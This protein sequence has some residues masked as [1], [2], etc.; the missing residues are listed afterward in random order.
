MIHT[1]FIQDEQHGRKMFKGDDIAI[2]E[3]VELWEF[4]DNALEELKVAFFRDTLPVVS[5]RVEQQSHDLLVG[6]IVL[7]GEE[8]FCEFV[9]FADGF[10]VGKVGVLLG[11]VGA[12]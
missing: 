8:F 10:G 12:E 5:I 1:A 9:D 3:M 7:G 2:V 11:E 6:E 4:G